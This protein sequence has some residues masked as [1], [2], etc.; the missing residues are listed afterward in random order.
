M[1][2]ENTAKILNQFSK[3]MTWKTC[4]PET[5]ILYQTGSFNKFKEICLLNHF[6]SKL[7]LNFFSTSVTFWLT[8][9][10]HHWS[11]RANCKLVKWLFIKLPL[12]QFGIETTF[13]EKVKRDKVVWSRL[14]LPFRL[15]PSGP[16]DRVNRLVANNQVT[17]QPRRLSLHN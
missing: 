5:K 6:K 12:D 10:W 8:V 9:R 16:A 17:L 3:F 4:N 13:W 7:K 15:E 14:T 2:F 1:V 11:F